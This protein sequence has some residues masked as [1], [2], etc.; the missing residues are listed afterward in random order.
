MPVSTVGIPTVST[1][2]GIHV[3]ISGTAV[4]I[5]MIIT[6]IS[7]IIVVAIPVYVSTVGMSR[8][9]TLAGALTSLA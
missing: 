4:A 9:A 8:L 1:I 2:P 7:T 3:A 6:T 5:V